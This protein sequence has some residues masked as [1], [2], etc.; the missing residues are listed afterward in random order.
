MEPPPEVE[1]FASQYMRVLGWLVVVVALA[2]G[3]VHLLKRF[4]PGAPRRGGRDLIEVLGRASVTP[5]HQLVAV[6]VAEK[7]LVLGAAPERLSL[8]AEMRDPRE[9]I[10]AL[11]GGRFEEE[12]AHSGT[13]YDEEPTAAH[14]EEG[15]PVEPYRREID[16]LRRMVANWRLSTARVERT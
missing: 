2:V 6:R 4:H 16:R 12:L 5:K 11:Q 7:V 8:I 9:V 3:S 1:S 10:G 14:A 15:A 13:Q